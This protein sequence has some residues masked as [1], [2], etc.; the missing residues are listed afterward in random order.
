MKR[1]L[2]ARWYSYEKTYE[3]R[4]NGLE[5]KPHVNFSNFQYSANKCSLLLQKQNGSH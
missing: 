2:Y 3:L 5:D 4:L 1:S